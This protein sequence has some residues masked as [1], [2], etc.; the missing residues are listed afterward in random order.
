M[1]FKSHSAA[2]QQ[3]ADLFEEDREF[4]LSQ[5]PRL[6][7]LRA[8]KKAALTAAKPRLQVARK[9]ALA[10]PRSSSGS[11]EHIPAMRGE[12]ATTS[13]LASGHVLRV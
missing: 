11:S 6:A 8:G 13:G 3:V 2:L 4:A 1:V 10:S 5:P 12:A 9:P 7:P